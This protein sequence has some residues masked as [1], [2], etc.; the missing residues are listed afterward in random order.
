MRAKDQAEQEEVLVADPAPPETK[1]KIMRLKV[2]GRRE[3]SIFRYGLD[4]LQLAVLS[5]LS[6]RIKPIKRLTEL[7]TKP[8]KQTLC[9]KLQIN[10]RSF[11]VY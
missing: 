1:V 3:K 4:E 9:T 5:W 6:N 10:E 7:I 11:V 2:H 8:I